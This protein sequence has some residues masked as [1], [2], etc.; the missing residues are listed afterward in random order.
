MAAGRCMCRAQSRAGQE[1]ECPL[2]AMLCWLVNSCGFEYSSLH[3]WHGKVQQRIQAAAC[4]ATSKRCITTCGV[5][6]MELPPMTRC[7]CGRPTYAANPAKT[8]QKAW[9][10][11]SQLSAG[12]CAHRPGAAAGEQRLT[13]QDN[14]TALPACL[15]QCIHITVPA[16]CPQSAPAPPLCTPLRKNSH[17]HV[18]ST[19]PTPT[20]PAKVVS[21]KGGRL[22]ISG[23]GRVGARAW[24]GGG[25]TSW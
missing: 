22:V 6:N 10:A 16:C 25:S 9:G 13:N 17:N 8:R 14:A 20:L 2:I 23:W 24:Q 15:Q 11:C 18:P 4:M 12:L 21:L 7:T 5:H 19:C 3:V 1:R